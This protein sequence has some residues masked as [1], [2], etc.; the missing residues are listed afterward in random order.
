VT[1][2]ADLAGARPGGAGYRHGETP[3]AAEGRAALWDARCEPDRLSSNRVG[4]CHGG[5]LLGDHDRVRA[6]ERVG[7]VVDLLSCPIARPERPVLRE[8]MGVL[9]RHRA[10]ARMHG[11]LELIRRLHAG[12]EAVPHDHL[13]RVLPQTGPAHQSRV[14]PRTRR[15][16]G[17]RTDY[18]IP[19][20][21]RCSSSEGQ[22]CQQHQHDRHAPH[23]KKSTPL[24]GESNRRRGP[25]R[26]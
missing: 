12:D 6:L 1:G 18:W 20:T 22:G 2:R 21:R 3:G 4:E 24:V 11:I 10:S 25:S 13:D 19:A 16:R 14:L 8:E 7:A 23:L 15:R 26:P 9:S 5:E 17:P